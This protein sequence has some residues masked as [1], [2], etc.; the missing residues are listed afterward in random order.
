MTDYTGPDNSATLSNV[1]GENVCVKNEGQMVEWHHV[2]SGGSV[3]SATPM[4][5]NQEYRIRLFGGSSHT[6][7][8]YTQKDPYTCQNVRTSYSQQC[9]KEVGNV[10]LH[11]KELL[12]TVSIEQDKFVCNVSKTNETIKSTVSPGPVWIYVNIKFGKAKICLETANAK[13]LHF[14]DICGENILFEDNNY[15]ARLSK[16][17]PSAIC[18]I[19]KPLSVR[20]MIKFDLK[21]DTSGSGT[22][23]PHYYS[24]A[25]GV[26]SLSPQDLRSTA[27]ELFSVSNNVTSLKSQQS[28]SHLGMMEIFEKS[29]KTKDA[30]D[31]LLKVRRT[32]ETHITYKHSSQTGNDVAKTVNSPVYLILELFRASVSVVQDS[33]SE[34]Y[35]DLTR[36]GDADVEDLKLK[37]AKSKEPSEDTWDSSS[38]DKGSSGRT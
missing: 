13:R 31:G 35:A 32:D 4:N 15:I 6:D 11:R 14:H 24:V 7:V 29:G 25:L 8:G 23:P 33:S 12:V 17:I 30:C 3:F 10:R 1:C 36:G 16:E 26:S 28:K 5:P 18:C 2:Y 20:D 9:F 21:P 34:G 37:S 27:P 22:E 38:G 19:Q